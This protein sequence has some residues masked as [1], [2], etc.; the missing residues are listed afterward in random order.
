MKIWRHTLSVI[1]LAG[2]LLLLLAAAALAQ[3]VE[4]TGTGTALP[5]LQELRAELDRQWEGMPGRVTKGAVGAAGVAAAQAAAREALTFS[6]RVRPD[7]T[8][9]SGG[10]TDV[11]ATTSTTSTVTSSTTSTTATTSTN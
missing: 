4:Q 7:G 6:L 9:S 8:V 5:S 2:G 11:T 1:G 10:S 3:N